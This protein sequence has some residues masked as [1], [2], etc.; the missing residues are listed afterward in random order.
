M[1]LSNLTLNQKIWR[2][3]PI[4]LFYFAL[5]GTFI[6]YVARF[7]TV[8]GLSAAQAGIIVAIVNGVNVF[9][10]FLISFLADKSGRRMVYIRVG[11]LAIGVFY[12]LSMFGSGFW[13]YLTVFGLFGI[14][15]SAVLPQMESVAISVLGDQRS[16]YGQVRLWGSIGFV[17]TVWLLGYLIDMFSVI[18]IPLLGSIVSLFMFISTFLIPERKRK[19]V[20]AEGDEQISVPVAEETPVNWG[21]VVALLVVILLWQFSMAP[22]NTFFDLY[23]REHGASAAMS[24]FLISFG[25]ICEIAT[26]IYIARLF[27]KYSERSL[28]IFTLLVTI[29]RWFMLAS[30]PNSFVVVLATQVCHAITFGVMHSVVVHR[31][32]TLFPASRASFGQGLYVAIGAGIGL[33]AGN[34]MAGALWDGTGKVYFVATFWAFLA[35]LVTWFFVKDDNLHEEKKA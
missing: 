11:Y 5:F 8:N 19:P 26:F 17:T 21:Q 1:P 12:F 25:S 27:S 2:L 4:Y 16:R 15:L 31:I 18:V 32:G 7:L 22:Y 20:A 14:F 30:F 29:G 23:M 13:F 24:G 28:L 10:P 6:P 3:S 34:L 9:A 35:L 33:F